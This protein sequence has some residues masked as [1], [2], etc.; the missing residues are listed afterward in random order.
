[1]AKEFADDRVNFVL[2]SGTKLRAPMNAKDASERT[3]L[4]SRYI[5]LRDEIRQIFI[6]AESWNTNSPHAKRQKID[7]DPHGELAELLAHVEKVIAGAVD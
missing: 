5:T 6:D 4:L 7:P 1:M 3:R 2:N